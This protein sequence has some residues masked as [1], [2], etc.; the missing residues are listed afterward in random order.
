MNDHVERK[1]SK[2]FLVTHSHSF[3]SF[4]FLFVRAIAVCVYALP[5]GKLCHV[6]DEESW[7]SSSCPVSYVLWT[8]NNKLAY[9]VR[10]QKLQDSTVSWGSTSGSSSKQHFP[11]SLPIWWLSIMSFARMETFLFSLPLFCFSWTFRKCWHFHL[12]FTLRSLCLS[13]ANK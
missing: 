11:Q 5:P 9:G 6:E 12:F 4:L 13:M 8:G 10:F 3:P 2:L 1:S 7:V